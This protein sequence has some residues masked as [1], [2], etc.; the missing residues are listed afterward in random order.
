VLLFIRERSERDHQGLV[1]GTQP[2]DR[3][4]CVIV[5][6]Q[7]GQT[8]SRASGRL[9]P[10]AAI[11]LAENIARDPKQPRPGARTRNASTP[12]QSPR[13]YERRFGGLAVRVYGY[14]G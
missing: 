6:D 12:S 4:G 9:N 8:E 10:T 1:R 3:L 11:A 5:K 7:L 14:G 13:F 2:R